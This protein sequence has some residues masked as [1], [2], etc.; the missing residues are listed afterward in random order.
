MTQQSP[1]LHRR[2]SLEASLEADFGVNGL[3]LK[4]E[5]LWET[6]DLPDKVRLF[7]FVLFWLQLVPLLG[8]QEMMKLIVEMTGLSPEPG[9]MFHLMF[10]MINGTIAH[11]NVAKEEV[12]S[13]VYSRP[14]FTMRWGQF[15]AIGVKDVAKLQRSVSFAA[16]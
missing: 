5:H 9:M 15:V 12:S 3:A 16:L 6:S 4:V 1:H 11:Q 13:I 8:G 10:H 7:R 14:T 2:W